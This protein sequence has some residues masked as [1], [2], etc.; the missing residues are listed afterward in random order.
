[1]VLVSRQGAAEDNISLLF[2]NLLIN[3]EDYQEY[4]D[5]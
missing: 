5:Q 1:M 3:E 2:V 4:F